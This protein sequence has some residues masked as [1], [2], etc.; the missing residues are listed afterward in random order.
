[1]LI[2]Q[3]I[4]AVLLSTTAL[5]WP[6]QGLATTSTLPTGGAFVAGSGS[7]AQSGATMTVTQTSTRGIVNWRD[8]SIGAGGTVQVNNGAGATL[9]RVTGGNLSEIMGTLRATGTLYL[10]NPQGVVVGSSGVVV[11]GGSFVA[12]TLDV[13]D[14]HFMAGGSL[15][16]KGDSAGS[17]TNLGK[18]SSTGGDVILI[19]REVVNQGT[20]KAPKGTAALASGTEILL[21]ESGQGGERVFV[22]VGNADGGGRVETSGRIKAAQVELKAAGG[23]VYALA[24][25]NG[26]LVRAAGSENREGRVWLTAGTGANGQGGTVVTEGKVT[27]KNADGSGGRIDVAA[28]GMA[29]HTGT[30]AARGT[31]GGTV[32]VSAGRVVNQG[33]ISADGK[34]GAGGRVEVKAAQRYLDTSGARTTA[35]GKGGAGGTVSITAQGS[36]FASGRV[37]ATGSTAGGKVDLFGDTVKLVGATVDA[38]GRTGGGSIRV[39]GDYQGGGSAPRS[40]LTFVSPAA[41]LRAD[42]LTGGAGGRIIVWSDTATTFAGTASARGG[43]AGGGVGG[44]DGGFI[45]VS[46]K[47]LLTFAGTA[48]AGATAGAA[49]RLLLD[50]KNIVISDAGS[51]PQFELTDPAPASDNGFGTAVVALSGGNVVVTSPNDD[52]GASNA[53]AV[54]LFN[55]STGALISTLAGSSANDGVG[56]GGVTTLS[57]GNYVV[58]S[59]AWKSGNATGAGAVTWASGTSGVSGVVSSGNSLVGTTAND[60]VGNGGVTALTN[61]NYVVSSFNWN[62]SSVGN[63]GAATW[64][65]GT[66]G[67]AGSVSSSNS[68]V[69]SKDN[70]NVSRAVNSA[71][72]ITALTN[73]NYVV[74]STSWDS[75]VAT[76]VGAVTWS[77]GTSGI[78]GVVSSSNSLVGST[79]SDSVGGSGIAVLSGGGYVVVSTSWDTTGAAN[80]GAVSWGSGTAAV[81]G[82]VSSTNSLIGAHANDGVGGSGITVLTN[83]NYVVRSTGWDGAASNVGAATWGNG[84]AA[85]TGVISSSNSL[86]GSRSGDSVGGIVTALS[87]GNYVVASSAWDLTSG[88]STILNAGAVTWGNGTSGVSGLVTT[89]NSLT[90]SSGNDAIGSAGVIA[91]TSGRY[92]VVSTAWSNGT[93]T[94]V[95]AVTWSGGGGAITGT[96]S[97]SNSLVG[98]TSGDTVGGGGVTVLSNGNYVVASTA[99]DS[100]AAANVGAV[101]WANGSTGLTGAVSSSN[102]LVGATAVDAVGSGGVTALSNGNYVVASSAWRNGG[103]SNAGAV[104]WASGT[105]ATTGTVSS[106]NSLV[107]TTAGDAVGSRGVTTLGNGNYVVVSTA[108]NNGGTVSS[109]GAVTWGSGT[110]GVTGAVTAWSAPRRTTPWASPASRC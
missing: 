85:T 104:T 40:Q 90:G 4:R 53:G 20:V 48:D 50:P 99:W 103:A 44:G 43:A 27:A 37:E 17:V 32:S 98:T 19:A 16:F 29:M 78:T 54:Y 26:G 100:T 72:G 22:R 71:S 24:G 18:I 58:A 87:D 86:V 12:S 89:S 84:T 57:N 1:M 66:S 70:D 21:T 45:E 10:V 56:S 13:P 107:G 42:S 109:A 8:F 92:V 91:L 102:S 110:G 97:S 75:S 52:T 23:N 76:N 15:V 5:L 69:G 94:S 73:G 30:L 14:A 74:R 55:G 49:G 60:R 62:A 108:W 9:N 93:I 96:V 79:S 51:Y 36:L 88:G 2:A 47:D 34:T 25:N 6:L 38:S 31:T 64:G 7:I 41:A 101:T 3:P 63:V 83:G 105:A 95:G 68:L 35:N 28:D 81:T 59:S 39:G 61:G 67:V 80:V 65:S 82:R 11:T 33:R 46:S 106:G 77:S